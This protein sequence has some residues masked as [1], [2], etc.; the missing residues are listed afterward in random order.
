MKTFF[1][2]HRV[3]L[4]AFAIVL[5]FGVITG[6][7][8]GGTIRFSMS[9]EPFETVADARERTERVDIDRSEP[10]EAPLYLSARTIARMTEAIENRRN[11]TI[12]IRNFVIINR[13]EN[14]WTWSKPDEEQTK[15][16]KKKAA[17]LTEKVFGKSYEELTNES[18]DKAQIYLLTDSTGY[19]E[20]ILRVTDT[21]TAYL[22]TLNAYSGK[23]INADLL[24]YPEHE[25]MD[26]GADIGRI[27]R[28]LGYTR[29]N[30]DR[31]LSKDVYESREVSVSTNLQDCVC[32]TYFGDRLSQVAIYPNYEMMTECA[33]FAADIQ[34]DYSTPAYP[35]HFEEAE[36]PQK[37]ES[38]MVTEQM[39]RRKLK[40]LYQAL[41]GEQLDD[42]A[43][44]VTFLKDLSG[45]REDCWQVAGKGFLIVI[46]AY[47]R[48]VISF[49]SEVPCKMLLTID[50]EHMGGVEYEQVTEQIA[51]I[52][53]SFANN[54]TVKSIGVNAVHDGHCCTM[55]FELEDGAFYECSFKDGVLTSV[56]Y[57][58]SELY[59]W[60]DARSGWVADG[61]Y[62]NAATK[63][64]IIPDFPQWD[65]DLHVIHPDE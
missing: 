20:P 24:A 56:E 52:F 28:A 23:L 65:G 61:V 37:G 21:E 16:A 47:S 19:R 30:Y 10:T 3:L 32:I 14:I 62:V 1:K 38:E 33:Y 59:F 6:L 51:R 49:E 43:I 17:E 2:K 41:S 36:P 64:K 35:E 48:H 34:Y 18:L 53:G 55:D 12:P 58:P 11:Y 60:R 9:S 63:E 57:W 40:R 45:A 15:L 13:A 5:G 44:T 7:V 29:F 22:L 54:P 31:D 25:D 26:F 4:I 8:I 46:S 50:Y 27:L 39:V 42:S